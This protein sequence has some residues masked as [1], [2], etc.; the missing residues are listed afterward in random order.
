MGYQDNIEHQLRMLDVTWQAF[1]ENGVTPETELI[2][3]FAY[4]C[5]N[6]K[7]AESL[8]EALEDYESAIR[9]EGLLKKK[10]YVEGKTHPTQVTKEVLAQWLDFMV[11]LGWQ[12]GSEFDGFGASMP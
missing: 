10:W 12:H 8:D 9:S 2:F 4:L 7:A 5:P 6:R 1:E 3:E 11:A